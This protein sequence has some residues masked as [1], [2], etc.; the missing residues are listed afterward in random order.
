M[1]AVEYQRSREAYEKFCDRDDL[2]RSEG[3]AADW[4]FDDT[5]PKPDEERTTYC[6]THLALLNVYLQVDRSR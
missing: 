1:V 5:Q 6:R 2:R 3:R 4:W